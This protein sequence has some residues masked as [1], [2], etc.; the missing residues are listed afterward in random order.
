MKTSAEP[1]R[2]AVVVAHGSLRGRG[3]QAELRE[4]MSALVR[5]LRT[6]LRRD[7]PCIEVEL[8]CVASADTLR[9]P[10]LVPA[11]AIVVID[12]QRRDDRLPLFVGRLLGGGVPCIVVCQE[13]VERGMGGSWLRGLDVVSYAS[14]EELVREHGSLEREL[15][16]TITHG[17][18]H[19]EAIYRFW[20]PRET[21]TVWVVCPQ[22]PSP[23]EFADR[24]SPDYT[25]LDNLGDTDA[26][27]DVMV[28]LSQYYPNATIE[29]FSA[30][31]LPHGRTSGNLVVIGGPGASGDI[32]NE[33]CREMMRE[34]GSRV[35]YSPDCEQMIISRGKEG[36]VVRTAPIRGGTRRGRTWTGPPGAMP[37]LRV[38]RAR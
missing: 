10:G 20:F 18:I 16:R 8:H 22:I 37:G 27:L 35:S 11:C 17:R 5:R 1:L 36:T 19:E 38:L 34:V 7:Y 15:A 26:L 21:S 9:A 28:F 13:D 31:D 33:I 12:A 29:R 4:G 25:Y 14:L 32:S 6:V 23:G 30:T 3:A 2:V 24:S